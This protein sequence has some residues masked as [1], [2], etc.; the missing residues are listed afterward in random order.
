M[1]PY[2]V[3]GTELGAQEW[4]DSLFLKYGL[5]TPDHPH[6]CDGYNANFF[7]CHALDCKRGG[8]LTARYNELCDRVADLSSK[9]FTPSHERNEPLIFACFSV[10]RPNEK[11]A[12][13]IGTTVL[14]NT[15]P[16]EAT[17]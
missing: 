9:A 14:Y 4:H 2:T 17:A 6:Y 5:D 3:N 11:P 13:T 16:L 7:I 8:V 10:K 12:R 1:Q 15:L